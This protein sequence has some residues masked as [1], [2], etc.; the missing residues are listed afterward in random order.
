MVISMK[1]PYYS[2][3]YV[4]DYVIP[5]DANSTGEDIHGQAIVTA[6]LILNEETGKYDLE[7]YVEDP[8]V[9]DGSYL[10]DEPL[11]ERFT[12][13]LGSVGLSW[14]DINDD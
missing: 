2:F 3:E 7:E 5:A 4:H 14:D 1:E 9:D 11:C 13:D 12:N 10:W 8:E 6:E